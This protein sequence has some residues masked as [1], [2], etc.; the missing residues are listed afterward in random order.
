MRVTGRGVSCGEGR[1]GGGRVV[2]EGGSRRGGGGVVGRGNILMCGGGGGGD[3][4]GS[5]REMGRGESSG[6]GRRGGG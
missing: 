2:G 3:G 5:V 4:K 1:G 6:R